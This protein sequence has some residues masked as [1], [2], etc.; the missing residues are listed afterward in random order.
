MR[1]FLQ[2]LMG[3]FVIMAIVYGV[4]KLWLNRF[5]ADSSGVANDQDG[6]VAEGEKPFSEELGDWVKSPNGR[7]A[8][9]I[10]AGL[11]FFMAIERIVSVGDEIP[12]NYAPAPSQDR[13]ITTK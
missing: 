4:R 8:I 13:P 6:M 5:A 10:L 1:I 7:V 12:T 2:L 3:I 11:F 9:I